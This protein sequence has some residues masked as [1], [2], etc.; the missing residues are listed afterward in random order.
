MPADRHIEMAVELELALP[1]QPI[2]TKIW[3]TEKNSLYKQRFGKKRA[4]NVEPL[5]KIVRAGGKICGSSDSPVTEIDPLAGIDA[6]VNNPAESRR[7]SLDEALKIF[8]ING[9]WAAHEEKERGSIEVGKAADMVVLDR[10][11][12]A[13]PE[14]ISNLQVEMTFV[15]GKLLYEKTCDKQQVERDAFG[16]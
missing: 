11:P 12:Y 16:A 9:A 1:M 14:E 4:E 3:D 10:S 2:F 15:E 7:I 6:C 8:T 5:A 13:A